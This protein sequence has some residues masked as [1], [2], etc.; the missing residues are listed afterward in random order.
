RT[1]KEYPPKDIDYEQYNNQTLE[2]Y[3]A[4]EEGSGLFTIIILVL[5]AALLFGLLIGLII[6]TGILSGLPKI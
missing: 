3:E 4:K 6:F 5:I 2:E 1:N